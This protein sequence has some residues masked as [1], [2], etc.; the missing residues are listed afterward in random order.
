MKPRFKKFTI[1]NSVSFSLNTN[2]WIA[3]LNGNSDDDKKNLTYS[4]KNNSYTH[5]LRNVIATF[6]FSNIVYISYQLYLRF[7]LRKNNA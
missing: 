4:Y 3:C 6:Y 2:V 7:I 5:K 1:L